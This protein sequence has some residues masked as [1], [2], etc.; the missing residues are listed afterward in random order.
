[1]KK[2]ISISR[3]RGNVKIGLSLKANNY[4]WLF[5][6]RRKVFRKTLIVGQTNLFIFISSLYNILV[7]DNKLFLVFTSVLTS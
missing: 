1:M 7:D 4:G 6:I 5:N 3:E 2:P